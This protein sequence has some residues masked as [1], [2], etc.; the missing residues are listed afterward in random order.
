MDHF[1]IAIV[2]DSTCDIPQPLADKYQIKIVYHTIIFGNKEFKDRLE[3]SSEGF[4]R[5]LDEG[6][7]IP[8]TA[9]ASIQDFYEVF[10]ALKNQGAKEILVFVVSSALSGSHQS[11]TN[12]AGMVDIPVH[13]IDSKGTTMSLGWQVLTAARVREKGGNLEQMIN[14]SAKVRKS[15]VLIV[16]MNTVEYLFHGG[17]IGLA[18]KLIGSALQIKPVVMINH[19]NGIVE[20]DGSARTYRNMVEMVYRR[21][22]EKIIRQG[23]LHIAV[24]HGGAVSEAE[25]LA[26]RIRK[27][28]NPFELFINL[29]TP[30][31]GVNT[32]PKAVAICG[33][34]E[35]E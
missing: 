28:F 11:A 1:P 6:G 32:G 25:N 14:D 23:K 17:R 9:Q 2:T 30:V 5:K 33:Y 29:T 35:E 7:P 22:G 27:D 18:K 34:S 12:A 4:Y 31:L 24:L 13:I 26:E 21:F 15:L 8:T 16:G 19:E 3:M 10:Q 20:P